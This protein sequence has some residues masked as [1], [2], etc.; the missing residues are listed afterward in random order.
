MADNLEQFESDTQLWQAFKEGSVWAFDAVY[1]R[2][3][4]SLYNYGFNLCHNAALTEDTIQDLFI[5]LYDH[6]A[7]LGPTDNIQYYLFRSLRRR[8]AKAQ[9]RKEVLEADGYQFDQAQFMCDD[10]GSQWIADETTRQQQQAIRAF[11]NELPKRQKEAIFLL[12][13]K[14]FSYTEVADTM[15]LEIKSVY[16]LVNKAIQYLRRH[17]YNK[18]MFIL[19]LFSSLVYYFSR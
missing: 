17:V 1:Q 12:Y 13:M 15:D 2:H 3:I 18:D 7:T 6:K 19:L 5:Y 11:V 9:T 8:L 14:G 4:K 10:I 16:N